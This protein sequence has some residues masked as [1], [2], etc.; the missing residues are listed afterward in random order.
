MLQLQ[1]RVVAST[2]HGSMQDVVRKVGHLYSSE[3]ERLRPALTRNDE[4]YTCTT[5]STFH[6]GQKLQAAA[7]AAAAART[8]QHCMPLQRRSLSS[9]S[10]PPLGAIACTCRRRA[11][12]KKANFLR[13]KKPEEYTGERASSQPALSLV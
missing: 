11:G 13:E 8:V 7:A 2:G 4:P 5:A 9:F 6:H 3:A 1:E 12:E 10:F